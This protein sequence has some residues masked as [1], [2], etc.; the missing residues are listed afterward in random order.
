MNV[1]WVDNSAAKYPDHITEIGTFNSF[2]WYIDTS[3][4]PPV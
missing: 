3:Y 1:K 2:T 4:W